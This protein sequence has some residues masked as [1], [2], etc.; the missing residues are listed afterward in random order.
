MRAGFDWW[1]WPWREWGHGE[2][3]DAFAEWGGAFAYG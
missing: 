2:T 1:G 3:L